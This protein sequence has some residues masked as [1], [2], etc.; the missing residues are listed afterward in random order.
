MRARL[1]FAAAS[2][3]LGSTSGLRHA[4]ALGLAVL[5]LQTLLGGTRL[6]LLARIH[7]RNWKII[8]GRGRINRRGPLLSGRRWSIILVPKI[9]FRTSESCNRDALRETL[10]VLA[11]HLV[12]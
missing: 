2:A 6:L 5:L 10:V 4:L 7:L 1:T 12:R 11:Y 9:H 8:G 3:V